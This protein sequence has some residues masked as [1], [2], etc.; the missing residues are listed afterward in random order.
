MF[1]QRWRQLL[2]SPIIEFC[3]PLPLLGVFFWFGGNLM[4]EQILSRPYGSVNKLQANTQFDVKLSLTVV[5]I[6]AEINRTKGATLVIVKTKDPSLKKL[7]FE[8]PTT[9]AN[10]VEIDIAQELD[11]TI[12]N[13][14]KL[15]RYRIKD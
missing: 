11:I 14:R 2:H 1:L 9:N 10:Q 5:L 8:F 4:A 15:V 3:L 13:V 12:A 6:Q 7:E